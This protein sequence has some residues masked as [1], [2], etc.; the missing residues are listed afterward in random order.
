MIGI[1]EAIRQM[2]YI[3]MFVELLTID[4]C[5]LL[6]CSVRDN[7]VE[8]A[9]DERVGVALS[10]DTCEPT[11]EKAGVLEHLPH[12]RIAPIIGHLLRPDFDNKIVVSTIEHSG[13]RENLVNVDAHHVLTRLFECILERLLILRCLT[14]TIRNETISIANENEYT[15]LVGSVKRRDVGYGVGV[16][17]NQCELI[18][19][20]DFIKS[21]L[22]KS[23]DVRA[24]VL[25]KLVIF[26]IIWLKFIITQSFSYFVL[27]FRNFFVIILQILSSSE[28]FHHDH[29]VFSHLRSH[30]EESILLLILSKIDDIGPSLLVF[31]L[32]V[33][34]EFVE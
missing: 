7:G 10:T 19:I 34:E 11:V 6:G 9:V 25:F 21:T 13:T 29:L 31:G 12:R 33:F 5:D 8:E 2:R 16:H 24:V 3:G 32:E 18:G 20:K 17:E 27:H 14:L 26:V 15:S 22:K 1:S 28:L 23:L 4:S 30:F